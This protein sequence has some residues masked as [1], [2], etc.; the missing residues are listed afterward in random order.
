MKARRELSGKGR[1]EFGAML[2]AALEEMGIEREYFEGYYDN[3][4]EELKETVDIM[5]I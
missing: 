1:D 5:G 3:R 4:K 2:A